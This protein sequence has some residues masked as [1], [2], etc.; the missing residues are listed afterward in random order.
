M[1]EQLVD[2]VGDMVASIHEYAQ[3]KGISYK[4]AFNYLYKFG[5][6]DFLEKNYHVEHTLSYIQTIE[7]LDTLC[8]R[9][10]GTL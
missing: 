10:G 7:H 2:Q 9:N 5:G 3:N 4:D 6:I 1:S 8:K